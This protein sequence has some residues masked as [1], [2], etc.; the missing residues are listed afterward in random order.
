MKKVHFLLF[1]L[2]AVF[3]LSSCATS[4][5]K[6]GVSGQGPVHRSVL[7]SDDGAGI[8]YVVDGDA[9]TTMQNMEA[10]IKK[11]LG[12]EGNATEKEVAKI[13]RD[14][15]KIGGTP[16]FHIT[17]AKAEQHARIFK[18]RFL[19]ALGAPHPATSQ[20]VSISP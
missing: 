18:T 5:P 10:M 4:T 7:A 14:A 17:K 2:L 1:L 8:D 13:Y 15:D 16:D 20:P 3:V 12:E 11:G 6:D 9:V 19:D